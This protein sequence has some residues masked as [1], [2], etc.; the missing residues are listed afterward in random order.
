MI[1]VDARDEICDM[2]GK[3]LDPLVELEKERVSHNSVDPPA[4]KAV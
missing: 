1:G 2:L 4:V 3:V